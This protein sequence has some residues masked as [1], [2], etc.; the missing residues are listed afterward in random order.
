MTNQF[1][2]IRWGRVLWTALTVYGASFLTIFIIV[3]IYATS[4]AVQAQGA[5]DPSMIQAFAARNAPWIGKACFILFTF[6]GTL[7]M[8]R[9]VKTAI[10]LH[11]LALGI[12]VSLVN[13]IFEGRGSLGLDTLITM[14]LIIGSGWLGG[15]FAAKRE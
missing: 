13:L 7:W 2:Q 1:S 5:P 15:W 11:G 10:E 3:T 4:L 6:L 12:L 8:A 9:F 14:L